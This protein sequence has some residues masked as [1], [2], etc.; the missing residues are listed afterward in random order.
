MSST[1]SSTTKRPNAQDREREARSPRPRSTIR[2]VPLKDE[3]LAR[4]VTLA[5]GFM[6]FIPLLLIVWAFSAFVYPH[7]RGSVEDMLRALL[8]AII[9]SMFIGYFVLKRTIAAVIE[10][11]HHARTVAQEQIG[12]SLESSN[13]NEIGELTRTFNR[14]TRE[15]EHKIEELESSRTLIKR[16]L[17]RIGTAIVSYE[18][19]DNLLELIVE[20]ASV[21]LGA[22]MGSLMLVNGEKQELEAKT[23]WSAESRRVSATRMKIGEGI[24]GWVAKENRAIRGTG[25]PA[26]IGLSNGQAKE[27]V[28]LCVPLIVRDKTIGVLSVLR[29]DPPKP[30]TEDDESLLANIG[31]Q[32]AV[33]IENYRLNLD[34]ERTYIETIMALA[35]A[36]EAKDSYSAGHSKRVAFYAVKIAEALGADEETKTVLND[37]GLLHDVGKIGTRDAIL[38]KAGPLTPEELRIMQQHSIIGEAILKPV[39]SLA[40]VAE[41]VRH[42][43]EHYDGS[44]YPSGLKGEDIPLG[45]RILTVADIYDSMITD[46]PYRKRLSVDE[47]KAELRKQSG[48]LCDPQV[49]DALLK[50]LA[51]KETRLSPTD[52]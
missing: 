52:S 36:V 27:G 24:A 19:I 47:A 3:R 13:G 40:K 39:R 35:L 6:S 18:G 46:R 32:I 4:K 1:T 22:S 45:A 7:V 51:E 12:E 48:A 2:V 26:S 23:V 42:H 41:L 44:G 5:F 14:I 11:V 25:S 33:A 38:L 20:N 15:L 50:I 29:E 9:F 43:H 34:V 16:L 30:F 10:V 28:V 8:A 49:V 17:S 31:S 21:G 37:A